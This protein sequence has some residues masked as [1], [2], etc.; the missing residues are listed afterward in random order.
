MII[1]GWKNTQKIPFQSRLFLL[2]NEPQNTI[3]LDARQLWK[4]REKKGEHKLVIK[5][6]DNMSNISQMDK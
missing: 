3:E 6:I 4:R 2:Q 1:R 5:V